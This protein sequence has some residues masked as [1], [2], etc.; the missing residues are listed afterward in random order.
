[1]YFFAW[2]HLATQYTYISFSLGFA[3][4]ADMASY[5]KCVEII[6]K[7]ASKNR[8]EQSNGDAKVGFFWDSGLLESEE[9][10][11]IGI[12][13]H[14]D[15]IVALIE[16]GEAADLARSFISKAV[17]HLDKEH[18]GKLYASGCG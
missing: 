10:L 14:V 15:I 5:E 3:F 4:F 12:A 13:T 16:E 7:K 2:Q 1:M 8:L 17:L 18:G 11:Q 9:K 6:L